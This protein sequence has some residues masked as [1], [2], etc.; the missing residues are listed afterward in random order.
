MMF[1]SQI[2]R[3]I[4]GCASG[5]GRGWEKRIFFHRHHWKLKENGF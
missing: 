4:S 5:R 1:I 2:A 3:G